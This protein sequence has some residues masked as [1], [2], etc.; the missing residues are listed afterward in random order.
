MKDIDYKK[1]TQEDI[2]KGNK[3]SKEIEYSTLDF[4]K[5]L[6]EDNKKEKGE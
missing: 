1:I 4:V 5:D 6:F 2:D 3:Y